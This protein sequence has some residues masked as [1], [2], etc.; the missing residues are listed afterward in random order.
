ML[1]NPKRTVSIPKFL[2][3]SAEQLAHS[4]DVSFSELFT[5]ALKAY[6]NTHQLEDVSEALNRGDEAESSTL[7]P[8]LIAL[9]IE[10]VGE[11]RWKDPNND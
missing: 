4:L 10:S 1:D 8:V 3:E 2:Y 5:I 7:E 11:N 6:L 9:Q